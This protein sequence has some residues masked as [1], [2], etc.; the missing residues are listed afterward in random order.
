LGGEREPEFVG[1]SK[2][3]MEVCEVVAEG[4][5]MAVVEV[6]AKPWVGSLRASLHEG[7][8]SEFGGPSRT[9]QVLTVDSRVVTAAERVGCKWRRR[10]N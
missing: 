7:G 8:D 2:V 5:G 9:R 3:T 10:T 6:A 1:G 4:A